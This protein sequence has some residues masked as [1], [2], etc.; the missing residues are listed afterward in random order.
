MEKRLSHLALC[1]AVDAAYVPRAT[2]VIALV[3]TVPSVAMAAAHQR[4]DTLSLAHSQVLYPYPGSAAGTFAATHLV[5]ALHALEMGLLETGLAEDVHKVVA[6]GHLK[7]IV[8]AL[9][10]FHPGHIAN[11]NMLV[12]L[13]ALCQAGALVVL[14]LPRFSLINHSQ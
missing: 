1:A 13:I 2:A 8:A 6:V 10:L 3:A 7:V 11:H 9:S 14:R 4:I 12:A 5:A